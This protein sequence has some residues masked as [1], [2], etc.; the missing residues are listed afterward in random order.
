[1]GQAR[2]ALDEAEQGTLATPAVYGIGLP[3]ANAVTALNRSRAAFDADAAGQLAPPVAAGAV[4]LAIGLLTAQG[5]PQIATGGL[6]GIDRFVTDRQ[7]LFEAGTVGDLLGATVLADQ[8]GHRLPRPVGDPGT[9][10]ARTGAV[11]GHF[12]G[13][14][15]PV[16]ALTA[17][18]A[19]LPADGR[20]AAARMAAISSCG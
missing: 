12:L 17:V 11:L 13:L 8:V 15:G 1:V 14:F 4:A 9:G 7:R 18:A 6:L 5:R 10:A 16:T 20:G 3:V 2:T 19:Q